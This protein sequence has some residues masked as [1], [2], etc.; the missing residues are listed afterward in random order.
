MGA[1]VVLQRFFTYSRARSRTGLTAT[2][3]CIIRLP[4]RSPSSSLGEPSVKDAV[5]PPEADDQCR[6]LDGRRDHDRLMPCQESWTPASS[7]VPNV[8]VTPLTCVAVSGASAL[9]PSHL[10]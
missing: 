9:S 3:P 7:H 2:V 6:E 10:G 1:K 5:A 8:T 4:C